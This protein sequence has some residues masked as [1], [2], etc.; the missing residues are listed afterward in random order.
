[1]SRGFSLV[2]LLVGL[3]VGL[4]VVA[5]AAVMAVA[6]LGEH[7]RLTLETQTQQDLRAAAGLIARELRKAGRWDRPEAGLWREDG[8]AAVL[9]PYQALRIGDGGRQIEFSLAE[10]P[11]TTPV[12]H[13]FR[14]H[15]EQLEFRLGDSGYQPLTDPTRLIVTR[16]E[17]A[18]RERSV[19]L[20]EGCALPCTDAAACPRRDWRELEVLIEARARHDPRVRRDARFQVELQGEA[21]QGACSP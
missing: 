18:L 14:L 16:F 6:Q 10:R 15:G 11:G 7:R 17:L 4:F 9:N 19:S 2:E 1:M 12:T 3:A 20:R 5:G 8:P 13:G 21:L